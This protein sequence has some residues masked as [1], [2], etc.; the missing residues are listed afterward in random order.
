MPQEAEGPE[1][2]RVRAPSSG[3]EDATALQ[4]G[5]ELECGSPGARLSQCSEDHAAD[6]PCGPLSPNL[7]RPLRGADPRRGSA[8]TGSTPP[9]RY[10]DHSSQGRSLKLPGQRPHACPP[11]SKTEKMLNKD[12]VQLRA[13]R[14]FGQ[15]SS[16]GCQ[17]KHTISSKDVLT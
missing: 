2:R 16:T 17:D 13:K 10:R 12:R 5:S 15:I 14:I 3:V 8:S 11:D 7:T 1:I 6:R 4:E 9:H